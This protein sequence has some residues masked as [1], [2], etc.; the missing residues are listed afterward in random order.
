MNKSRKGMILTIPYI[1]LALFFLILPL[2]G[3]IFKSFSQG[4]GS[5][6]RVL[7]N[8]L[9]IEGLKNSMILSV[10][11]TAESAAAGSIIAVLWYKRLAKHSWF[12]SFLNYSANNGGIGLAFALLA[13]L[14][15][16]GFLT[17]ILRRIGIRIYPNFDIVS[18]TGIHFA[19]LSFLV[20]YMTILFLPAVG[21]LKPEWWSAACTLGAGKKRYMLKIAGPVL[22]P[23]FMA[24]T[25]LVFL[26]SLGTYATAQAISSDR[27]NLITI[28]IGYLM[29][30]SLFRQVDAYTIS[31]LLFLIMM[32][33]IVIYKKTNEKAGRWLR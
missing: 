31:I 10:W 6:I 4:L 7:S 12:L 3:L 16:N 14:G 9:Y 17:I 1:V 32:I 18:L 2:T 8:P 30:M 5:W 13:T 22:F 21:S 29:Q 23:S 20:P 19:Y 15:T 25:T 33:F 26:T 11:V 27:I 28:Q 24:S